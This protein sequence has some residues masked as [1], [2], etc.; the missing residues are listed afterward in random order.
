[1]ATGSFCCRWTN[2]APP[3]F[4]CKSSLCAAGGCLLSLLGEERTQ[5]WF[6][7]IIYQLG[8]PVIAGRQELWFESLQARTTARSSPLLVLW[9]TGHWTYSARRRVALPFQQLSTEAAGAVFCMKPCVL[10]AI[11]ASFLGQS[12]EEGGY[13]IWDV[14]RCAVMTKLFLSNKTQAAWGNKKHEI[15]IQEKV[16]GVFRGGMPDILRIV[17]LEQTVPTTKKLY[18]L[19]LQCLQPS[20]V[21]SWLC[22]ICLRVR[23]TAQLN[24]CWFNSWETVRN[25]SGVWLTPKLL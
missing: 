21:P 22:A 11:W 13:L 7:F 8:S 18:F 12:S 4:C 5:T 20:T 14:C 6:I 25:S 16:I 23:K 17:F 15:L 19:K 10:G 24:P 9:T 3:C 2:I 1:M